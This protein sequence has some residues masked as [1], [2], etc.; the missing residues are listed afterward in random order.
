[1]HSLGSLTAPPNVDPRYMALYGL[2]P[3]DQIDRR[4]HLL[5]G[6]RAKMSDNER[7][8]L[9]KVVRIITDHLNEHNPYVKLLRTRAELAAANV[10]ADPQPMFNVSPLP[11]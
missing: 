4:I 11:P 6:P 10:H 3:N 7:E 9:N 1:M 2:S 5:A 8:K